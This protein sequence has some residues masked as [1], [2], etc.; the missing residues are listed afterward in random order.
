[1]KISL[2]LRSFQ[3]IVFA[4]AF[5][6]SCKSSTDTEPL[7]SKFEMKAESKVYKTGDFGVPEI[8]EIPV[9]I[10]NVSK[11]D[12]LI[13][14]GARGFSFLF[15]ADSA[16]SGEPAWMSGGNLETG[17]WAIGKKYQ[18]KLS[19]FLAGETRTY[20]GRI[21]SYLQAPLPSGTY[22]VTVKFFFENQIILL[23]AGHVAIS[24]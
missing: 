4:I 13:R 19:K 14:Y 18:P 3:G 23:D 12:V 24:P 11:T 15:Y 16:K 20:T 1:M 7:L 21:F 6:G 9:T 17:G 22:F 2:N 5:C 8:V 10:K